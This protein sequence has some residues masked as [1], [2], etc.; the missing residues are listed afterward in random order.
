M[1][2][3]H[4]ICQDLNMTG[5]QMYQRRKDEPQLDELVAEYENLDQRIVAAEEPTSTFISD[6]EMIAMKSDRLDLKDKIMQRVQSSE[7]GN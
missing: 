6:E 5:E 2:A 1:S 3:P 7:A 4:D